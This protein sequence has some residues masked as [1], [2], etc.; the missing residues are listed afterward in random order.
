MENQENKSVIAAFDFDG[1]ITTKDTLFDFIQYSFGWPK[2]II[3]MLLFLPT[4][5]SYLLK[6]ISN[7]AAKE[8]LF[9]I[10][11]KG[12]EFEDFQK[13]GENY[14]KKIN[15]ILNYETIGKINWHK[16]EGD[17]LIIISAS[18]ENWIEPWA[19]ECG[20]EYVLATKAEV[21]DGKLT[22]K[23]SSKNCHGAEKVNRLLAEFPDRRMYTLYAYGDSS[24]DTEL[25]A[26]AEFSFFKKFN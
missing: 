11:F 26:E 1:T 18:I 25:L 20:F 8:K 10:F 16:N 12:F 7:S 3:G 2:F 15:Q 14:I 9:S 5:T 6:N 13:L 21:K 17:K 23:F 4:F 22:G 19:K 24:G